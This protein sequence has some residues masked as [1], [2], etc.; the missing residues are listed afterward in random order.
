M[1]AE[2]LVA[3]GIVITLDQRHASPGAA[4]EYRRRASSNTGSDDC[5]IVLGL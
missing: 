4:K 1:R 3:C 2:L 5:N